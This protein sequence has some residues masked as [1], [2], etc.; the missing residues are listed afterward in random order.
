MIRSRR[1]RMLLAKYPSGATPVNCQRSD[2]TYLWEATRSRPVQRLAHQPIFIIVRRPRH[3]NTAHQQLALRHQRASRHHLVGLE[4]SPLAS[5]W[6][7][8]HVSSLANDRSVACGDLYFRLHRQS[9]RS[10]SALNSIVQRRALTLF[11]LDMGRPWS[12]MY[13]AEARQA[14]R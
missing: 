13:T 14:I 12:H 1:S 5:R 8:T 9:L 6:T 7:G 4:C 10:R 3:A 2:L 11:V